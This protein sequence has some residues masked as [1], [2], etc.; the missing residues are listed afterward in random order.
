VVA[1]VTY[2][3]LGDLAQLLPILA[4]Q[5]AGCPQPAQVLVVD[6]DPDG[7]AGATVA[8]AALPCV[9]YVHEPAPGIAAARNRALAEAASSDVLVFVDDDER[10]VDGWLEMLLHAHDRAGGCGVVGPVVSRFSV[11][12]DPWVE[13]GAF[14]RRRRMPSGTPVCTAATNNLLLDMSTVRR[15]GVQFDPSLGLSGGSDTL[16]TRQLTARAGPL[17]WC[18][19]AIVTDVV[20]TERCARAWVTRRQFRSGNSWSRTAVLQ[21][22][23]GRRIVVRIGLSGAGTARVLVGGVRVLAGILTHRLAH[24]AGGTR[25]ALRGMGMLLGAWGFVYAEYRRSPRTAPASP[26]DGPQ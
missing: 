16:F 26:P 19:E 3:R 6:N 21:A 22:P 2:R 9:R 4:D 23:V 11:P 17:T 5:V 20:P 8:E 1:V 24:R 14:F 13:A 10:P 7:G 18:N 25:T 12:L 15:T